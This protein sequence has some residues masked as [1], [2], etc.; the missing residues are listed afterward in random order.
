[1]SQNI[2][3]I[4]ASGFVGS[5]LARHFV[6]KGHDVLGLA[7]SDRAETALGGAGVRT[8]RGDL[9]T[10]MAPVLAAARSADAVV[11]AAQIAF[12]REPAVV[13][14][15]C[16]ELAG[17][18]KTLI[19]LSGTGVFMQRTGG[20]WSADSFAEDDPF[21]PEPL[22]LPRVEAEGIVRAA[23]ENGLRSMVVRPPVIWGP[24][25]NGPVAGVYRSVALT[26][27]ACYIGA[28]LA[29]Y[30]N[31]HSADLARLF[32]LAIERG[33]GGALYHAVAGE[34]PYRWIAEAVARDLG[35]G[36]RSLAMDEAAE[37]FDPFG[38][39]LQSACS[40]SRDPRTRSELGWQPTQFDMLSEVGEPRLRAL[41]NAQSEAGANV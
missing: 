27:A 19:F 7:R 37:V 9:D 26:G 22:A 40:R 1:M 12:D 20:A 32:S 38:V 16:D 15:L 17:S 11:Y 6:A 5:T 23:A 2:F 36:T 10:D 30:S 18:G 25:D 34:I 41:A 33:Q 13:R 28:G 14:K 39:L 31:V 24:G 29:A 4:G 3:I 8:I 21:V 35:V